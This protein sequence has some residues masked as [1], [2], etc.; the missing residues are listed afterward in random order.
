MPERTQ[1]LPAPVKGL[2]FVSLFNDFASEMVYP[3]L[4]AFI[5]GP[6][7]GTALALGTLDGAAD[8]TAALV[9]GVSGRLAD[10]KGWTKPLILVGYGVAVLIRPIISVAS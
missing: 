8:L 4:P 2:S 6:L 9:R 10:R 1:A 3:V 7:G 5:T